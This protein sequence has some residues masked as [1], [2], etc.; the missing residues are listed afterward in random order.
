MI[1]RDQF[2]KKMQEVQSI[3]S[4]CGATLKSTCLKDKDG[5]I[6]QAYWQVEG[7]GHILFRQYWPFTQKSS[8]QLNE[9]AVER[10]LYADV[11]R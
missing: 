2:N 4:V 10:I 3:L 9:E 6:Y 7:K 11:T 5:Q 1:D 8:Y